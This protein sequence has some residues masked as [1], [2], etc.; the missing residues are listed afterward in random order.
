MNIVQQV[1][2]TRKKPRVIRKAGDYAHK[3]SLMSAEEARLEK[4]REESRKKA[5]G[6]LLG[7]DRSDSNPA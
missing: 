2:M 4:V 5:L 1:N 6:G 7:V 3:R